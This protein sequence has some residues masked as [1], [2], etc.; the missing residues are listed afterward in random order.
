MAN[1]DEQPSF[2]T[3]PAMTFTPYKIRGECQHSMS[4]DS[5]PSMASF[6]MQP[7]LSFSYHGPTGAGHGST[8]TLSL[9]GSQ[10]VTSSGFCLPEDKSSHLPSIIHLSQDQVAEIY[11]LVRVPRTPC[12]S[13]PEVLM[14]LHPQGNTMDCCPSYCP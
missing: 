4:I 13:G 14:P 10:H 5:I 6:D 3:P 1:R 12:G 2:L 9:S 11:Q 7:Y 8:P